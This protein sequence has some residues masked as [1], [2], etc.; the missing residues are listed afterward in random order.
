MSA[1]AS[2]RRMFFVI[3]SS[4]DWDDICQLFTS[5]DDIYIYISPF[6]DERIDVLFYILLFFSTTDAIPLLVSH[7]FDT[8]F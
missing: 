1:L 7:L 5:I 2:I 3:L 4:I 6:E 8:Y